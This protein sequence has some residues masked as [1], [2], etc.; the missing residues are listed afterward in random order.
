MVSMSLALVITVKV[1]RSYGIPQPQVARIML[2]PFALMTAEEMPTWF[3]KVGNNTSQLVRKGRAGN[4]LLLTWSMMG[5]V[6]MFGFTCNL[7]AIYMR[8]DHE[9]PLD[10]AKSIFESGKILDI[11]SSL[12]M[13]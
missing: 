12:L 11:N 3:E 8:V 13:F 1:G 2:T 5:M 10:T 6:I 9:K 4:I 7:R